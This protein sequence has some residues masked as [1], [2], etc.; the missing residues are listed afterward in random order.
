MNKYHSNSTS[1]SVRVGGPARLW[2]LPFS[3]ISTVADSSFRRSSPSAVRA[4]ERSW[5]D[6]S[7][8]DQHCNPPRSQLCRCQHTTRLALNFALFR[9]RCLTDHVPDLDGKPSRHAIFNERPI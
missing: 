2:N 1:A 8:T 6:C 7:A 3:V 4:M 5:L 9:T